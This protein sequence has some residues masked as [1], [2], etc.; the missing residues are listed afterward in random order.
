M[1]KPFN[2]YGLIILFSFFLFPAGLE[3]EAK[4]PVLETQPLISM[5]LQDAG[6]KDILKMLSIQSGLNFIASEGV[7]ERKIT[8]Y[9]DNVPLDKA[10]DKLFKANNLSYDLDKGAGI[11]IVKD[12]GRPQ[13]ETVTRVFYLKHATVSTSSLKKEIASQETSAAG[14][15]SSSTGSS[16]TTGSLAG[17][18]ATASGTS[19]T[20]AEEEFG[21][22]R[23]VRKLLSEF[24]SVIEDPRTNSLIVT[25]VPSKIAVITQVIT[26]LDV[27]VPQVMLEVEMLDVNK[28]T[29]DKLGIKFGQ[30][31]IT[32]NT[33]LKGATWVNSFPFG[34]WFGKD[35]A[36]TFGAFSANDGT[37]NAAV[38]AYTILLD[39]LKTQSDTKYLARPRI[40]T[41]NNQTAEIRISGNETLNVT[42]STLSGA[43]ITE[44]TSSQP[45]KEET[46]VKLRVTPQINVDTGEVTMFIVPTLKEA[47]TNSAF[48]TTTQIIKDVEERSTKSLVRVKDGETVIIGGL[49]RNRFSQTIT[50]LPFFGDIPVVGGFFRHKNK[51]TDSEREL[52]VFITPHIV[53]DTNIK[54]AQVKSAALPER[55]QDVFSGIGRR[56]LAINSAL[57][58]FEKIKK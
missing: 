33:V 55:E 57:N 2:F 46:G 37:T 7:Q 30:T 27:P 20:Q 32:L 34:D 23:A 51:D 45:E 8:L 10:M 19:S 18:S 56:D 29:I 9:L 3:A 16:T 1:K 35:S 14:A 50:K 38:S 22:T 41:L 48:T 39:F 49:I 28:S 40:L 12:W 6:L 31:P 26:A 36:T 5:D 24:G 17:S 44:Q 53:K 25:D 52:L 47:A 58:N 15:S 21:I 11:F 4:L 43:S 42:N 54:L 13:V